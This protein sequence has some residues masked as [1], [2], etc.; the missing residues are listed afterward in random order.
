MSIIK[1]E[2]IFELLELLAHPGSFALEPEVLRS[3]ELSTV[4]VAVKSVALSLPEDVLVCF[5]LCLAVTRKQVL[6]NP[7]SLFLDIEVQYVLLEQ[8]ERVSSDEVF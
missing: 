5:L 2:E 1:L 4:S 6:T 3:V 7:C 8:T